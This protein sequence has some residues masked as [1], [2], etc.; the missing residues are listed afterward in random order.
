[1]E[2]KY[3]YIMWYLSS[4]FISQK[5]AAGITNIKNRENDNSDKYDR[6]NCLH[7]ACSCLGW[8]FIA[9]LYFVACLGIYSVSAFYY[10]GVSISEMWNES[11]LVRLLS[12]K[13]IIVISGGVN[14]WP[15]SWWTRSFMYGDC[16][17]WWKNQEACALVIVD[18]PI[19]QIHL[20]FLNWLLQPAS[21]CF[22]FSIFTSCNVYLYSWNNLVYDPPFG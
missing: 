22:P 21:S 9:C 12:S 17:V 20:S 19:V 13:L 2:I 14:R 6:K 7:W 3:G 15:V 18:V 16:S 4:S 11:F 10:V 5:H 1:M 8:G